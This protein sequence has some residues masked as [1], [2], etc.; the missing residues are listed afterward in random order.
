MERERLQQEAKL[1]LKANEEEVRLRRRDSVQV[2]CSRFDVLLH[3]I[4]NIRKY[5]VDE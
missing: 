1:D 5:S 4:V 2:S 3:Q